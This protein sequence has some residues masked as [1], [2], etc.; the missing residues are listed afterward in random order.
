MNKKNIIGIIAVSLT[1]I[2]VSPAFSADSLATVIVI[3]TAKGYPVFDDIIETETEP[4]ID[5]DI[6]D[7]CGGVFAST[8]SIY[9]G[10]T[11]I[12]SG[13]KKPVFDPLMNVRPNILG[14]IHFPEFISGSGRKGLYG[15]VG[16][17][18]EVDFG[19]PVNIGQR[20]TNGFAVLFLVTGDSYLG[21]YFTINEIDTGR[22]IVRCGST[23]RIYFEYLTDGDVGGV[24]LEVLD[25]YD[26]PDST[27][28]YWKFGRG[29]ENVYHRYLPKTDG[30]WCAAEIR[31]SELEI[32]RTREGFFDIPLDTTRLFY[33]RFVIDGDVGKRGSLHIDNVYFP[34]IYWDGCPIG[35]PRS[36][37]Q[38]T[39]RKLQLSPVQTRYRHGSLLVSSG[40]GIGLSDG[41]IRI[42]DI[43]G[44]VV[45]DVSSSSAVGSPAVFPL[46]SIPAGIYIADI[47]GRNRAGENFAGRSRFVVS[48]GR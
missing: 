20:M 42:T 8:D 18:I 36:T 29:I 3:D 15:D 37:I 31:F 14:D 35:L 17:F 47:H 10:A 22:F 26:G 39:I 25:Y 45:A 41:S 9:G 43:R 21:K 32:D 40:G 19:P 2:A 11:A 48:G 16:A 30:K 1:A 6:Y 46:P 33:F 28:S 12:L 7:H 4:Y 44:N 23:N 34:G 5:F 27:Y 13:A 24:R 38:N